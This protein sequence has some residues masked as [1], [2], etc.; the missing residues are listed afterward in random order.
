MKL[1]PYIEEDLVLSDLSARTK[2]EALAELVRPLARKLDVDVESIQN[3]LMNREKLGTTGIGDSVAIPHGKAD[4]L[5]DLHVVV[6]R[7]KDGVDFAALD[8]KPV[9]I[10]FLVLAPEKS[11]G[12]H[13]KI[14][15]FISRTLLDDEVKREF[16]QASDKKEILE[17][18]KTL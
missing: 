12:K 4:F 16:L 7:S 3:I 9:H 5:D 2:E 13:L 14:L 18:L 10:F 6:G 1:E 15:A 11:A 8:Q 17:Y